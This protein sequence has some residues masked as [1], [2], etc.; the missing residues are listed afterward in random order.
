MSVTIIRNSSS[1]IE[2]RFLSS[3]KILFSSFFQQSK[4]KVSGKNR[5]VNT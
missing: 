1:V 5:I 3:L 2:G 4:R